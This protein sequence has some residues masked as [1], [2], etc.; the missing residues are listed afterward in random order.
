MLS[1]R[2]ENQRRRLQLQTRLRAL[3]FGPLM[4][5]SIVDRLRKCGRTNCACATDPTARHPGKYLSVHLDGRTQTLHLRPEDEQRVRAATEAYEQLWDLVNA[6]TSGEV[7]D[8][9]REARERQRS[10]SRRKV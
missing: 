6:L 1:H 3:T 4:R 7:A 8:L 5:G 10:R 2:E 9:R